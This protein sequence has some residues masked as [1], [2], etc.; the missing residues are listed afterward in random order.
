MHYNHYYTAYTTCFA[1]D[2]SQATQQ[3]IMDSRIQTGFY[4]IAIISHCVTPTEVPGMFLLSIV[5]GW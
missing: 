3:L 2:L 4:G 5:F 1:Y